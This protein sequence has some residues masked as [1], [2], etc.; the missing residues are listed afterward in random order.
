MPRIRLRLTPHGHLLLEDADDAPAVDDKLAA[1]LVDAFGRGSGNGLLRLGAGE[2][3]QSLPPTFV[4]WRDFAARYVGAVCLHASGAASEAPSAVPPPTESELGTLVLTAPMMPGAEYLNADVLL[5]LWTDLGAAFSASLVTSGSDLQAFL[6]ALNPAWNLVGR[7]HF[8]LAEN[9]QDAELPFAF[10]ATY[11]TRLSAQAKAKHVPLAEA[12]RDYAGAANRDKLLSLLM[13]VQRAADRYGWLKTMVDTGE[14]FHPLRWSP[15]EAARLLNSV[16]ELESAGVILRM[17]A[18]W[19]AGRPPR[20]QVTATIGA[21]PPSGAGLDALLDF[22]MDVTL[23]G[24][25][26][27]EEEMAALLAGTETLV[28]LR[29]QWVEIDRPRLEQ[30]IDRFKEV[31]DL[32]EEEGLSFVEAM[33]LLAGAAV[34]GEDA[35]TLVAD[36]SQVSAGPWLAETLKTLRNPEGGGVDPGSALKGTL[37]TY[38]KAGVEWLHLLSGLGLGACLADDMG[39]GKTIQV[40]SLLLIQKRKRSDRKASLLVAPASLLANWAAEIE[41]FAPDLKAK[42]VHSSAMTTED[43]K[44]LTAD[45]LSGLDLAITS[46]GSLLRMPLLGKTSWRLVVLDEAQ[47]IKNH[48]AKQTRA[49]KALKAEARI[50]L[51]GTPVENHLGDL[52]SIFDF[53]NPG[54]LGNTK[55]FGRFTKA[56]TERPH[57]PYGPLRDLVRPYILRRMKTDKSVIADLPDKTEVRSFCPLSRK[58]AALY[59]QTVADLAEALEDADGIR[60]RGIVLATMMRLK[61]ICNHPSQWLNDNEWAEK[62]SGKWGRLREIAEVVATRQEKMLVFTQFRET[63][64]PLAAY[65]GKIFGRP[66]LVLH[67]NTAVKD[68]KSLVRAFQE[69]ETVPFFVLSLKAGGSGLTLTAASH[70]VHFDRWWNPAVENQATDRAFRIG[71][72]KN[73]LVHK[74]VCQGTVEEQIDAMIEAKK[75]LSDDVMPDGDEIN[76]TEMKD[77]DLMRMVALDVKTAMEE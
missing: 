10:M 63:T 65:L 31:Q 6:K 41:R 30:A 22:D 54:L 69:D 74:F 73:V 15:T 53:I 35:Q 14:I 25:A 71:Q 62:D 45:R 7:V 48:R 26:L 28:L 64:A 9:R 75:G 44:H 67:G 49:A 58:Q 3:G 77:E 23:G 18:N 56:L 11:T 42:I 37:R 46:Y 32:A 20:P 55:E 59:S 52:W 36:W 43:L 19:H 50:A 39:L 16:P 4:W 17:P 13:P 60:R 33:R 47:A 72:K 24:E 12:L 40:L 51:T 61:Q 1:R 34:A 66:G 68:R 57:N 70:V 27:T 29:G 38:Q 8:N 2:V 76:L 21:R 5:G